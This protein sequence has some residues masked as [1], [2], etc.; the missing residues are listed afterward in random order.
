MKF[1]KL[2]ENNDTHEVLLRS[3]QKQIIST[4]KSL[5]S[6]TIYIEDLIIVSSYT[7]SATNVRNGDLLVYL[8]VFKSDTLL[9]RDAVESKLINFTQTSSNWM[10]DNNVDVAV[11]VTRSGE[12]LMLPYLALKLSKEEN[13]FIKANEGLKFSSV[14]KNILVSPILTC[15]QI[16]L[17]GNEFGVDW[18]DIRSEYSFSRFFYFSS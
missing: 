7:C 9:N 17:K 4:M 8:K 18:T 11:T 1:I 2:T 13:C 10:L 6:P 5:I 15:L 16:H 12:S 3:L 14:Y